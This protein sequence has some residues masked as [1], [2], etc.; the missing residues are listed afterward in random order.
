MRR[1]LVL[2]GNIVQALQPQF[3]Q[4]SYLGH[5]SMQHQTFAESS[6]L[7]IVSTALC[8]C[9]QS[10][11]KMTASQARQFETVSELINI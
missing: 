7:A 6:K 5:L 9:L 4:K 1:E 8:E 10:I 2:T 11:F 3:Q